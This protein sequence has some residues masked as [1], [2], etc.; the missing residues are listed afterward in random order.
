MAAGSDLL[1]DFFNTDVD[2]KVVSELVGS[3]E[4][5]LAAAAHHHH[6]HHHSQQPHPG[7]PEVRNQALANHVASPGVGAAAS[8]GVQ[9]EPKIGISPGMPKTG[10]SVPGVQGSVINNSRPQTAAQQPDDV[11]SAGSEAPGPLSQAKAGVLGTIAT[12]LPNHGSGNAKTTAL[13]TINGNNVVLN[14]HGPGGHAPAFQGNSNPVPGVNLVNNGPASVAKGGINAGANTVIQTSYLATTNVSASVISSSSSTPTPGA[15]AQPTGMAGVPTTVALGKQSTPAPEPQ[16]ED[17]NRTLS[18]E[19]RPRTGPQ[20]PSDQNRTGT[21]PGGLDR[22]W[23]LVAIQQEADCGFDFMPPILR[24]GPGPDPN[25]VDNLTCWGTEY[26]RMGDIRGVLEMVGN[27]LRAMT[28]DDVAVSRDR[29]VIGS[30]RKALLGML[31][32]GIIASIDHV[33]GKKSETYPFDRSHSSKL[34]IEVYG[35]MINH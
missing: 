32:A 13:Q 15:A 12:A 34:P 30:C 20:H 25:V 21:A 26:P 3:L 27:A 14:S 4:S 16:R 10:A 31:A 18:D 23:L 9:P 8:A 1:D 6:H 19:D 2:D 35:S 7:P 29:D 11:Q 24:M 22:T 28:S 33:W 17:K 5:Q